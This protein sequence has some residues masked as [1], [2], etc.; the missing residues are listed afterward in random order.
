[1]ATKKK[2]T[3]KTTTKSKSKKS[4][5][6]LSLNTLVTCAL[7]AVIGVLL[8]ILRGGSLEILMTVAGVFLIV[9]GIIDIVKNKNLVKGL[10][11]AL[12]GVAIILCGW[13]IADIVLLVFGIIL[14]V[15]G[16]MDLYATRKQGFMSML[17]AIVVI[18][19]GVLLVIAKWAL[20]DVMCIIAGVVFI[21]NAVLVLFGKKLA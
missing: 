9:L 3:K 13:L 4:G 17:P 8:L 18:A 19:I 11:E 7:Y 10:I 14:I 20:L 1:M 12:I 16:G 2:T 21:I 15:K 5:L 6:D